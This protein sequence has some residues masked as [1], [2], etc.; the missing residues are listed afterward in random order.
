M[1]SSSKN[2]HE[3]VRS[4]FSRV[5]IILT[6]CKLQTVFK[7]SVVSKS[8]SEKNGPMFKQKLSNV[9]NSWLYSKLMQLLLQ[10]NIKKFRLLFVV[11]TFHRSAHATDL[12][13]RCI[14]LATNH[15][16]NRGLINQNK[17][18]PYF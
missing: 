5:C 7:F 17:Q 16:A 15:L 6:V 9:L 4:A 2:T 10:I 11:N 18:S 12:V 13:E 8:Q 14:A 1:K 3:K